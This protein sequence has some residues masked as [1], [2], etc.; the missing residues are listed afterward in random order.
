MQ[1]SGVT[2]AGLTM[3]GQPTA[4]AGATWW[5][6]R[7][8][9]WLKA[10]TATT[11]PMGS[12]VVMARRFMEDA[13]SPMGISEP[14]WVRSV[15]MHS[16]TPSMARA[17]STRLSGRGL[18]P[19]RAASIARCSN[20]SPMIPAAFSR[21]PMRLSTVSQPSRSRNRRL[22]V[23]SAVSTAVRSATATVAISAP[24]HGAQTMV[25]RSDFA[26]GIIRG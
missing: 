1:D 10:L 2:S 7:F 11:T 23:S 19:S 26:P 17:T 24:S 21:M 4:T 16:F 25:S 14:C 9:G 3:Q 15:S 12:C 18:P 13:F 22:A 6:I 20:R 8:S 5:T